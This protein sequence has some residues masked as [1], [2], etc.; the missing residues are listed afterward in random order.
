MLHHWVT[1]IIFTQLQLT[2]ITVPSN[3]S[4]LISCLFISPSF[5]AYY[6]RFTIT[7]EPNASATVCPDRAV[8]RHAGYS[9]VLS[10]VSA[11]SSRTSTTAPLTSASTRKAGWSTAMHDLTSQPVMT[12]CTFSSHQ[13]TVFL[14]YRLVHWARRVASV[15]RHP[16]EPMVARWCAVEEATTPSRRRSSKDANANSSGAAMSSVGSAEHWL[17]YMFVNRTEHFAQN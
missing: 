11:P 2:V 15:T 14:T 1:T 16:W 5:Y 9:W 3:F 6:R 4:V 10:I 13:T 8:S 17:M 12:W 7:R